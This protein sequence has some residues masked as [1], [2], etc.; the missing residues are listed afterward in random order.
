MAKIALIPAVT[1]GLIGGPVALAGP[2]TAATS[3]RG[4]TVD[5]L[6]PTKQDNR[7]RGKTRVDFRIYVDCNGEQDRAD[8]PAAL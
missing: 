5:P 7:D 2:A 1:L 4:C 3:E 6:K 8:P